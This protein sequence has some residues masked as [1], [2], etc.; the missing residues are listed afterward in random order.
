MRVVNG[1]LLSADFDIE[2]TSEFLI[3]NDKMIGILDILELFFNL[4]R[5]FHHFAK[6]G[7]R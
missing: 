6:F 4:L 3:T 7:W 2:N 5:F 1:K